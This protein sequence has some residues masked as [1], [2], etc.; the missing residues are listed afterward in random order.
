MLLQSH[1]ANLHKH[2]QIDH[3]DSLLLSQPPQPRHNQILDLR[4][5]SILAKQGEECT[6]V[7][8]WLKAAGFENVQFEGVEGGRLLGEGVGGE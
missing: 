6:A 8:M 5:Q 4:G 2:S 7:G 3:P 1:F